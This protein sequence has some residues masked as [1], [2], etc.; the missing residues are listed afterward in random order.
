MKIVQYLQDAFTWM[1]SKIQA[2]WSRCQDEGP[3]IGHTAAAKVAGFLTS[4]LGAA[5]Y[6]LLKR[7]SGIV[8]TAV[9]VYLTIAA[10]LVTAL[11]VLGLCLILS[12]AL[13]QVTG[14]GPCLCKSRRQGQ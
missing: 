7:V 9:A 5:E 10:G 14:N 2:A 8:G 6:A 3:E 4:P 11:V 12:V 13:Y 1:K